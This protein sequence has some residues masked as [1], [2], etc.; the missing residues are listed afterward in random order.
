VTQGHRSDLPARHEMESALVEFAARGAIEVRYGCE[1]L[2]T[3]R[4]DDGGFAIVTSDGDFRCSACVFAIGVTDPWKP[5]IP[6]LDDAP[7][8][9]DALPPDRYA[10]KSIV[11][12]GKRN[13][14][15][16]LAQGLLPWVSKIVLASPRPVDTSVLA[17][18]PLGRLWF[19]TVAGLPPP[20]LLLA[21]TGLFL[22]LPAPALAA[23]QSLHQGTL[24]H[25][26]ATRGV[27]EAMCAMLVVTSL[28]LTAGVL[29]GRVPGFYVGA[30]AFTL[31]NA[32]QF[33]WLARR[34]RAL[35]A[36]GTA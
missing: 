7:H 26:H 5:P 29:W 35:A 32:A 3:R 15:F 1:W 9:A 30:L 20:L 10:G 18:S 11:I 33:A 31:G 36:S 19:G 6:G 34:A 21:T 8:Y 17:F 14:G 13:S 25:A 22:V 2:S 12:V 16:E 28:T 23:G 4:D 27:T 24:I